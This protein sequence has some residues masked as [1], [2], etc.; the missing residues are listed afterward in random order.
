MKLLV[1]DDDDVSRM[2]L[3]AMV[4]KAGY[5]PVALAMSGCSFL[6]AKIATEQQ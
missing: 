6:A 2:M 5:E 1:A 3:K 4:A